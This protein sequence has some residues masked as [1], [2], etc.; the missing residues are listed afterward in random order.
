[1]DK[2]WLQSNPGIKDSWYKQ[3]HL[4]LSHKESSKTQALQRWQAH[5]GLFLKHQWKACFR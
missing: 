3:V 4:L 1:M 5:S 2:P